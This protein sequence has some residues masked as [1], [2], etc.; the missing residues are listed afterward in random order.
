MRSKLLGAVLLLAGCTVGNSS[1]NRDGGVGDSARPGDKGV[2]DVCSDGQS[3]IEFYQERGNGP[4]NNP[5]ARMLF[6]DLV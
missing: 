3:E 1:L 4:T 2:P 6:P 5:E